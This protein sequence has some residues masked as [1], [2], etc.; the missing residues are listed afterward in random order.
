M[1]I[2]T[3]FL[4]GQ[5]TISET[6]VMT[7]V[8]NE[9]TLSGPADHLWTARFEQL[10]F[11]PWSDK[12]GEKILTIGQ[13]KENIILLSSFIPSNLNLTILSKNIQPFNP[14]FFLISIPWT[15]EKFKWQFEHTNISANSSTVIF[16]EWKSS[17]ASFYP[18]PFILDLPY[19]SSF[20]SKIF[21]MLLSSP[22]SHNSQN[23]M[24]SR[25]S[26]PACADFSLSAT[27]L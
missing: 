15:T 5:Q 7:T 14:Y 19:Y 13:R 3:V 12:T 22:C 4:A 16:W 6:Q 26:W 10:H 17:S 20:S 25:V 2:Q 1:L 24:L 9:K 27:W 8:L 23:N 21:L 11:L 18:W